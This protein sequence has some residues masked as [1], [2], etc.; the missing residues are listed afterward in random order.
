MRWT[1]SPA[2]S[3]CF[4]LATHDELHVRQVLTWLC[5]VVLT[6]S[7]RGACSQHVE[8]RG[9]TVFCQVRKIWQSIFLSRSCKIEDFPGMT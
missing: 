7:C 9:I 4:E 5:L 3:F 6:S 2:A 8:Q 1:G